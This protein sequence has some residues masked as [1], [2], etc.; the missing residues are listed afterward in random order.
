MLPSHGVYSASSPVER[1]LKKQV[2]A[3][4]A[5]KMVFLG[6]P[7]QVDKTTLAKQLLKSEAG[8]LNWDYPEHRQKI[9]QRI[10]E[11][12]GASARRAAQISQM[13]Q[14]PERTLRR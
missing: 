5:R 4:L 10:F 3:D 11:T 7:R 8:Y 1:Y 6:G 2:A 9:L 12:V 14:L 13:A